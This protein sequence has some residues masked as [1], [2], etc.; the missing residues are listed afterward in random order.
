MFIQLRKK[1]ICILQ[2]EDT[3]YKI[4]EIPLANG[5]DPQNLVVEI[6]EKYLS[7]IYIDPETQISM[8]VEYRISN[9]Y[10]IELIVSR[11]TY[12]YAFKSPLRVS[13]S[14]SSKNVYVLASDPQNNN[15]L[16]MLGFKS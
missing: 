1:I 11:A 6:F 9:P 14:E 3:I 2:E 16:V 4:K 15:Q 8:Y 7:L 13:Y 10:K 12:G 5:L